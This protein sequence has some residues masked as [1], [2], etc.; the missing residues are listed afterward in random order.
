MEL[1]KILVKIM[2]DKFTYVSERDGYSHIYIYGITGT[3]QKQLTSG[4]WDVTELLSVD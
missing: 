4:N 1:D 2:D 3:L